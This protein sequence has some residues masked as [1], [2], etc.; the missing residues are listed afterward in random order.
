MNKEYGGLRRVTYLPG[1]AAEDCEDDGDG[2]VRM[3]TAAKGGRGKDQIVAPPQNVPRRTIYHQRYLYSGNSG[4]RALMMLKQ[5]ARTERSHDSE[6]PC[7]VLRL[8]GAVLQRI[9]YVSDAL[10]RASR[11]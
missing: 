11:G 9:T 5:E 8:K 4:Q 2:W 6:A 10:C 3:A 1:E 7:P